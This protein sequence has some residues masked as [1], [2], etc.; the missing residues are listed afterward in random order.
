MKRVTFN[1]KDSGAN[2]P[3]QYERSPLQCVADGCKWKASASFGG[4]PWACV[5]HQAVEDARDWPGI[6]RRTAEF[7]WL[8]DFIAE[9][10]RGINFPKPKT[11]WRSSATEFFTG[12]DWPWLVP[13]ERE[14]GSPDLYINRLL[15]EARALVQGKARPQPFVPHSQSVEWTRAM[16]K[17]LVGTDNHG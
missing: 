5:G 4:A 7:Q 2:V 13:N 11:D 14:R 9:I 3:A 1:P 8:A 15:A 12:T 17:P 10:Q 16:R 6:T